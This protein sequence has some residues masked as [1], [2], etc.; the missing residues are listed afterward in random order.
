MI[1]FSDISWTQEGRQS[2]NRTAVTD[3]MH[4]SSVDKDGLVNK[5]SLLTQMTG[6]PALIVRWWVIC[7]IYHSC[8]VWLILW[9]HFWPR[10]IFDSHYR[11]LALFKMG[12]TAFYSH[13]I[14]T[15]TLGIWLLLPDLIS[16]SKVF[17]NRSLAIKCTDFKIN[18]SN[19]LFLPAS[20]W[21]LQ[22]HCS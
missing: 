7:C 20:G 22:V 15:L 6:H 12:K 16:F 10:L 8:F 11:F 18:V 1:V 4:K 17:Q 14:H 5:S 19:W 3:I 21:Y 13:F 2:G 9:L